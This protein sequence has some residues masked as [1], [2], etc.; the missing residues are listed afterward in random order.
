MAAVVSGERKGMP[1]LSV[2]KVIVRQATSKKPK[3]AVGVGLTN[4]LLITLAK[5]LPASLIGAML[6]SMYGG[7]ERQAPRIK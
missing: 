7:A 2:A 1:P 6:E 4:K 3:A 5:L